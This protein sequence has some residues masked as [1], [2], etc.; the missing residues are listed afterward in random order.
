[1]SYLIKSIRSSNILSWILFFNKVFEIKVRLSLPKPFY[2]ATIT[3]VSTTWLEHL[4]GYSNLNVLLRAP[5]QVFLV[6]HTVPITDFK[7]TIPQGM[8]KKVIIYSFSL[9]FSVLYCTLLK[10]FTLA[11]QKVCGLTKFCE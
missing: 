3:C 10:Y 8:I 1:M 5:L 4:L 7:K 9:I 6:V 2:L 11:F